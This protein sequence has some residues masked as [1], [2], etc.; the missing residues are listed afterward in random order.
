MRSFGQKK[1]G[2]EFFEPLPSGIGPVVQ[3]VTE[4]AR[5]FAGMGGK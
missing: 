4:K 3:W 2:R 5:E 1:S